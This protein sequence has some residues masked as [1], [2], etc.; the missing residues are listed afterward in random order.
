MKCA[1]CKRCASWK[2][3]TF[4]TLGPR[5][6][7]NAARVSA[8]RLKVLSFLLPS[9]RAFPFRQS[10]GSTVANMA[11][12][13]RRGDDVDMMETDDAQP[14][15]VRSQVNAVR[16][17]KGRGFRERV[18]V[19]DERNGSRGFEALEAGS[20]PGPA[21]CKY[22]AISPPL[23]LLYSDSV[24]SSPTQANLELRCYQKT[25]RRDT[26]DSFLAVHPGRLSLLNT[27]SC[28]WLVAI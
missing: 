7:G 17:Q 26:T 25:S 13:S 12:R 11:S 1:L 20:G 24:Y 21:K 19:D 4:L 23:D 22:F 14:Q 9:H 10:T 15:R 5:K 27:F 16:K 18:D 8:S 6:V 2:S 28:A 3:L